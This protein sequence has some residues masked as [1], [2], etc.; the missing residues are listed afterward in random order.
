MGVLSTCMGTTASGITAT[1]TV[2]PIRSSHAHDGLWFSKLRAYQLTTLWNGFNP[3]EAWPSA[4]RGALGKLPWRKAR[5]LVVAFSVDGWRKGRRRRSGFRGAVVA[6]VN[7]R[8][9]RKAL[10]RGRE[11]DPVVSRRQVC[12]VAGKAERRPNPTALP[13][14]NSFI[15]SKAL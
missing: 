1:L 8:W 6:L 12:G 10:G 2:S 4:F 3:S 5:M 13:T 14:A 11:S 15:F 9:C 7:S